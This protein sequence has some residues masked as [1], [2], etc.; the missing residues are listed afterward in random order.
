MTRAGSVSIE[1]MHIA[2]TAGDKNRK[3]ESMSGV[4]A[5][6]GKSAAAGWLK[7]WSL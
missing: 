5:G 6:I 3:G 7:A 2:E 1:S 4:G